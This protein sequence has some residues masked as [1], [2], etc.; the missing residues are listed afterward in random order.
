VLVDIS[1]AGRFVRS[2]GSAVRPY[3]RLSHC[4]HPAE[5]FRNCCKVRTASPPL[6]FLFQLQNRRK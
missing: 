3:R 1:R 2:S 4:P 6:A 5:E